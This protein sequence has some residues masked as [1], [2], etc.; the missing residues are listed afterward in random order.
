MLPLFI[1]SDEYCHINSTDEPS[2]TTACLENGFF[3]FNSSSG[4]FCISAD[5]IIEDKE[6]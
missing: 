4:P 3:T 2:V 1:S 5:A 6:E